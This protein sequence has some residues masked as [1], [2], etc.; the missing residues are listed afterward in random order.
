MV[1]RNLSINQ[2]T[3]RE[4][5]F[6]QPVVSVGSHPD[7]DITLTGPGVLPFHATVVLE[8][9]QYRL[10]PMEPG[11]LISVDGVQLQAPQVNLETSQR[12]E[13]GNNALF[14]QHNGTPSSMR[15]KLYPLAGE[16]EPQQYSLEGGEK[17][18]LLNVLAD[19]S[20]IDVEQS[21]VFEFEVINAGPIV[22]SFFVS[23]KGVP[24]NWVEISPDMINLN[25]GQRH[26]VQ[27]RVT[28]PRDAS[29]E[30]G[31]HTLRAY[32]TSPNYT[33]QKVSTDLS[34]TIRPYY[35]FT[36]GNL[37]PKDQRIS[38]RNKIGKVFLPITNQGNG[39]ADFNILALD[40][41]NGCSFDFRLDE[42]RLLNRQATTQ[43]QAGET[44]ELPIEITP[45]KHPMFSMRSKRY[46]YT[47]NV[48]IPQNAVAPQVI[49]GS[50]TSVPL[51]GWWSIVLGIAAVLLALFFI[52]QPNI[53]S[54]NVAA[55]KDV[56]ELG[57]TTRLDWDVSPFATRLSITNIDPPISRG[58]VSQTV[59]PVVSTTYELVSGNW[60]SGLVGLDQKKSL[61]ILVVP[62]S[63]LVNVFDID[64]TTI[65]KG[66]PVN[67]RWSVSTADEVFLTIDEVVY[68]LTQEEFS[69]ERQVILEKDALITL[70]AKTGSGSELQ[71]YFVNVV[72]PYININT[73]TIWVRPDGAASNPSSSPVA[74][75]SGGK[76]F[77]MVNAP[78]PNFPVKFV[79]LIPDVT[80]D[81]GYRVYFNPNVRT[82][83]NKGE[84]VMLEW[85]VEGVDTLQIAPF[86]DQLPARGSQPFFPQE[87][88]NFVMT[89][90]SGDLT[91]IFMLPV[92][93]FDG[94]PP[95]APKI[96][97]F[98]G[99]P[100][101][102]IGGGEVE[103]TWSVSGEWTRVTLSDINGI[104]ADNLNPVGFKKLPISV[105]STIILTAYNGDLSSAL[106]LEVVVDPALK[107][108]EIYIKS[109]YGEGGINDLRV[110][111][112]AGITI[113]FLK[114][115]INPND[116]NATPLP[117]P[118]GE[119]L[120][121]DGI[122]TCSISLPSVTC[123]LTFTTPGAPKSI[124]ATYYGDAIYAT[125]TSL[126][127][128]DISVLSST[129]NL[130]P[131]YYTL[132][133]PQN[134]KGSNIP[135]IG[136]ND[137]TMSAGVFVD[138]TVTPVSTVL[139]NDNK[140]K[141][142]VYVCKQDP[143]S[144]T[145]ISSSCVFV[146]VATVVPN[147]DGTQG[148]TSFAIP[149]FPRAGE[150][151]LRF[152]YHHEDNGIDPKTNVQYGV[153]VLKTGIYLN[154]TVCDINT[155]PVSGCSIGVADSTNAKI[156][157]D[158]KRS[159]GD[160]SLGSPL[161]IPVSSDFDVYEVDLSGSRTE[162][163]SCSVI[164]ATEGPNTVYKLECTGDLTNQGI[165]HLNYDFKNDVSENYYMGGDP[166]LDYSRTYFDILKTAS[167][168][169]VYPQNSYIVGKTINL[170]TS[171]AGGGVLSV[172]ANG[173]AITNSTGKLAISS[174]INGLFGVV[175]G[176]TCTLTTNGQGVENIAIGSVC[177]IYF[178]LEGS[179]D[180]TIS[181]PGDVN[182][183]P[184]STGISQQVL[185]KQDGVSLLWK[186]KD[187]TYL[188]L[189]FIQTSNSNIQ[190]RIVLPLP[191]G[192]TGK[193]LEGSSLD[194]A[195]SITQNTVPAGTCNISNSEGN[196]VTGAFPTYH[197]PIKYSQVTG[198][199][200][201]F[202]LDC[203]KQP[204][205]AK[206]DVS[207]ADQVNFAFAPDQP[208][209]QLMYFSTYTYASLTNS[210]NL[211]TS[212]LTR[213]EI[214]GLN[215]NQL[216][217]GESY[218][219]SAEIGPIYAII[220]KN[221]ADRVFL[222]AY[223]PGSYWS[224][225][226]ASLTEAYNRYRYPNWPNTGAFRT[227]DLS[228]P[229]YMVDQVD[230]TQS[231]C[232]STSIANDLK[233]PLNTYRTNVYY[234]TPDYDF[235]QIWLNNSPCTLVFNNVGLS[236]SNTGGAATFLFP[237]MQDL[238]LKYLTYGD[239]KTYTPT[240][241]N[242]QTLSA[243]SSPSSFTTV[244]RVN[245]PPQ[246]VTFTL[247]NPIP[248]S[249]L[250][251]LTSTNF[252]NWIG[253][254]IPTPA[255]CPGIDLSG[256]INGQV[257]TMVFTPPTGPC[258]GNFQISY[259]G[260]NG[261]Y[262][263]KVLVVNQPLSYTTAPLTTTVLSANPVTPT[264]YGQPVTFTAT[265]AVSG[266][267]PIPTGQV[268]FVAALTSGGPSIPL[269]SNVNLN[270]LGVATCTPS[271]PLN[272]GAYTV[273]ASFVPT[274][275]QSFGSSQGTLSHTIQPAATTVLVTSNNN[276][277]VF[278]QS[279]TFTANVQVVSPGVGTP[280]GTVQFKDGGG[281]LGPSSN[282]NSS[283]IATYTTTTLSAGTH[284]IT[285][286]YTPTGSNFSTSNNDAAPLSQVVS[287]DT[288]IELL[289]SDSDND[290][291]YGQSVTFTA[292]VTVDAPNSGSPLGTVQFYLGNSILDVP[293]TLNLVGGY[294]Q[295]T[296]NTS[297]LPVSNANLITA[298]YIPAST[299]FAAGDRSS[300]ISH[301]VRQVA[302]TTQLVITP[303]SPINTGV[304]VTF[305]V[306]VT[307]DY[308][309]LPVGTVY[310]YKGDTSSIV[311]TLSLPSTHPSGANVVEYKITYTT[312]GP[313]NNL[314]ARYDGNTNFAA[315]Q[316]APQSITIVTP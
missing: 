278:P 238:T 53:R 226:P 143:A 84:Q 181:Y 267:T 257:V 12:V 180:F 74:M 205:G 55:G 139:P 93:V 214:S 166:D 58:Q 92:K 206:M 285:A 94:I 87:S 141:I 110:G 49:S 127:N 243:V 286:V 263:D 61:T 265:V 201:D 203:N 298:Q 130:S 20:E 200:A 240:G 217:V 256:S 90:S 183:A 268:G 164:Y 186:Y 290:T 170:T 95:T 175:P 37:S 279:V 288:S 184:S 79:E 148:V 82:E 3:A 293:Q 103:L 289:S 100:L 311:A 56:I 140:G 209:S 198:A 89:A 115:P 14:F 259:Q 113:G 307:S 154:L 177:T 312:A 67:I 2:A 138:I 35:E 248:G 165:V 228:L 168:T 227:V 272:A 304:E 169:I 21:A 151:A 76:R 250:L 158:I 261:Y 207:L 96:E 314:Y 146:T 191:E 221:A 233:I 126:E 29:S 28:P 108:V 300:A 33:G 155:N 269:C 189:D 171:P 117:E 220:Y 133:K 249:T 142:D 86:T 31:T 132:L 176:S 111:Q 42:E 270:S 277:S 235:A 153:N 190:I 59:A 283:G 152:T 280:P 70:E 295:A 26:L 7:N 18:I 131:V 208:L 260:N 150:T 4:Y 41:E 38:W 104:V 213:N 192:V 5:D 51:F 187:G 216:Y 137:F 302:T 125:A 310:I 147:T 91:G 116:P 83:L 254:S 22:A 109:V 123:D 245:D 230:W 231:N 63:P 62:P 114:L 107:P 242:R 81:N 305:T 23:L 303:S 172:L 44:V 232:R 99:T 316:S 121:S 9:G 156:T 306:T 47:T 218:Q 193:V 72:P 16:D 45:I 215:L 251:P 309:A 80:S 296:L 32:I 112:K 282:L 237:T 163:W 273:T 271:S 40:D 182:S 71:S 178:K 124:K 69:G 264:K 253:T 77:S 211:V 6:D 210:F 222:P 75:A 106:P 97:F 157:F 46:H 128:T 102:M 225:M 66:Q 262:N 313:Q 129:V 118:T 52:L 291:F 194:I 54:F 196:V 229:Q 60:L 287:K 174:T 50:A 185:G 162:N 13:I 197:V 17:A 276:P 204:M 247:S 258:S 188:D 167:T 244:G 43:L 24:E 136:N 224:N 239:S 161:P 234:S 120:I 236:T 255:Q 159:S 119:V 308:G 85:N 73:F 252:G 292:R 36:V 315:S 19:E 241:L 27:I 246:T 173:S 57:D 15:V 88:M 30:A 98:R 284:T 199:Y 8:A 219:I 134:L 274:N 144:T 195:L 179:W 299:V 48:S 223:Y 10:I 202:L 105:S 122:S 297:T 78:D 34:L 294:M 266:G 65:S 145:I 64:K 281:N 301:R 149:Y 160:A 39:T 1:E 25:E 11:S 212:S 68:P 101:K 275:P 135:V